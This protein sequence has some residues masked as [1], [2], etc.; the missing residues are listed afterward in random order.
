MFG[1]KCQLCGYKRYIG[2]LDFHH[3]DPSTKKFS[4]SVKGLCYSWDTIVKEAKN[5]SFSVKIVI[6]KLRIK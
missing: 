4:L 1:G 5:V 6:P 2:A 3:K